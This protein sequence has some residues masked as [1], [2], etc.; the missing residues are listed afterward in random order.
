MAGEKNKN[1]YRK[2]I[3]RMEG[4]SSSSPS[5]EKIF[6]S[7]SSGKNSY[8]R[9]DRLESSSFDSSWITM[10]EDC[11]FDLGDI[12]NNP[13]QN[14][15]TVPNLVPVELARKVNAES[16][17][18]LASHTQFV[19]EVDEYGNVIPNKVLNIGHEDDIATYENRFI[20]TFIRRL[21]LFVE[22]RYEFVRHFATLHDEEI[23]Y[24]KSKSLVNGATVEIETK[25]KISTPNSDEAS[26]QSNAYVERIAKMR[27]YV[28]YYYNSPFMKALKTEKDVRNPILMTNI[29]RKNL[30]YHHC[31]EVYRFIESYDRLGVNYKVA[32]TYSKL[33]EQEIKELNLT[34]MANYLSVNG[35][36]GSTLNRSNTKVYKPKILLSKDDENFIYGPLLSGPIEFTRVDPGYREYLKSRVNEN[37]PHHPTKEEKAFYADEYQ[38]KKDVKVWE[39][40]TD[41]LIKRKEKEAA[42]F[43]KQVEKI[44]AERE[45]ARKRWAALEA[46]A[47]AKE[48][49]TLLN[50]LRRNIID[51]AQNEQWE[52]PP[53]EEPVIEEPLPVEE[54]TSIAE[55]PLP[56]EE[57]P[58]E[59]S[60]PVAE[61]PAPVEE[62]V[63]EAQPVIEEPVNEE[64]LP[65]EEE[66]KPEEPLPS[67]EA[68]VEE[69]AAP[70]EEVPAEEVASAPEENAV[71]EE[72]VPEPEP[73]VEEPAAEP[74]QEPV[75]EEAPV[76][77]PVLAESAKKAKPKKKP[78]KKKAP[79]KKK[80]AP[81]KE[82]PAPEPVPEPVPEPAPEPVEETPVEEPKKEEVKKPVKPK[83]KPAKQKPA[84]AKKAKPV[85]EKPLEEKPAEPE[86][87]P[88]PEPVVEEPLPVEPVQEPVVEETPVE[89]P[90]QEPV[91]EEKKPET[92][93]PAKKKPAKKAPLKLIP[94]AKGKKNAPKKK[95]P[96]P[97]K[98]P[99]E[100]P[101]REVIPGTFLVKTPWGYY[102]SPKKFSPNKADAKI[103]HDFNEAHDIKMTRGGK[104]VKQ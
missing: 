89:E 45:E 63:E 90:V 8:M 50:A 27:E 104:I 11:L 15:K 58:V 78:A 60:E 28:R 75:T 3:S 81:V 71:E 1:A 33:N 29:L 65:V 55:E 95:K 86:I 56:V 43:E 26:I 94:P 92:K 53:E 51:S 96:A 7:L 21:V 88:E 82:E 17:Q 5:E 41:A 97:A 25:V 10:I 76:A 98:K 36:E 47:I 69:E 66:I 13:R 16:V 77:E 64:P 6:S 102:V 31:Y 87:T 101:K 70:V 34:L 57:A 12:V 38:L 24:M 9:L 85:E 18:H 42:K 80:V 46:E 68:P 2:Y 32:E 48:E 74:V 99:A 22:K 23:V 72:V 73:V 37:L 67:E 49:E 62:P 100:K 20:A 19:K 83:K 84:R 35:K 61:E 44:L 30:K 54:E 4:L 93:V 103:F 91:K 39:K 59:E 40:E 79:V 52:L 14:T